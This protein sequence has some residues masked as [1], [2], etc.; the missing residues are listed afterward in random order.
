M[1]QPSTDDASTTDPFKPP[2][3][4]WRRRLARLRGSSIEFDLRPYA[5]TLRQ[6]RRLGA[7]LS[8]RDDGELAAHLHDLAQ[9]A[10]ND[11]PLD[12]LLP[13]TYALVCEAARRA[14]GLAPYDVQILA[15]MALHQ[16][17]V[18]EMQTGEGKTLAA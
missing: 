16:G 14:V 4:T 17:N 9:E 12:S 7:T 2:P 15:A 3:M 18:V 11:E 5:E 6:V 8:E 1:P 10:R 13:W